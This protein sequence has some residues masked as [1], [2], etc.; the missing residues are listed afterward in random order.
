MILVLGLLLQL[1]A[2]SQPLGALDIYLNRVAHLAQPEFSLGE[3]ATVVSSDGRTRS[4]LESLRLGETPEHLT[5]LPV[6]LIRAQVEA[7]RG[8]RG[9]RGD[10]VFFIGD[11]IALIPRAVVAEQEAWFY[12]QLLRDLDRN[13]VRKEGRVE[14]ELLTRPPLSTLDAGPVSFELTGAQAALDYPAGTIPIRY[15][16]QSTPDKAGVFRVLVHH[17]LPVARAAR[18]LKAG[19]II[20]ADDLV[21]E[22]LDLAER[23]GSYLTTA[24]FDAPHRVHLAAKRGTLIRRFQVSRVMAVQAGAEVKLCFRSQ[25]LLVSVPGRAAGSGI[26][27]EAV[28]VRVAGTQRPFTGIITALK[29]V[30]IE[31]P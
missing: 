20:A 14:I 19:E 17:F 8:D 2:I 6:R 22:E 16:L 12:E 7:G 25:G 3:V 23:P 10:R 1:L 26:V 9:D 24:D 21:F 30:T 11:R 15:R 5:L 29:E 27:G 4:L 18:E 31:L 28:E 13:L